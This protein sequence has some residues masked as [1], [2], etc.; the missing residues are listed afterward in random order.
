MVGSDTVSDPFCL[1][2]LNTC[3]KFATDKNVRT[4]LEREARGEREGR[5]GDTPWIGDIED[6]VLT[7]V[8]SG[9]NLM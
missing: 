8:P 5:G 1:A 4:A 2:I 9:L 6:R 7:H 3:S